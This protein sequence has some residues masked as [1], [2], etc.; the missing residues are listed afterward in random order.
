MSDGVEVA[1]AALAIAWT[2]YTSFF[3]DVPHGTQKQLAA[4]IQLAGGEDF[5]IRMGQATKI[6]KMSRG[7]AK[8]AKQQK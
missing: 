2:Q 6:A 4:L 8:M 1:G 7:V 5:L 3:R